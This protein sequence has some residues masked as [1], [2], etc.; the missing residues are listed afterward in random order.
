MNEKNYILIAA[1]FKGEEANADY[2]L[3]LYAMYIIPRNR[4]GAAG[5]FTKEEK[6]YFYG[7]AQPFN[8][9]NFRKEQ[10]G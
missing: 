2:P 7:R 4:P 9:K 5:T 10:S 6:E 8:R 3:S 1:R